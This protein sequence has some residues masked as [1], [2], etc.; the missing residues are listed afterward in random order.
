MW[1][2]WLT[3]DRAWIGSMVVVFV[4][5]GV[6]AWWGRVPDGASS[7]GV[8]PQS[9]FQAPDFELDSLE[10]GSTRL[11]DLR[12]QV[13]VVNLWAT[14]CGPCRAEMSALE[15][16]WQ[17]YRD[18]GLV[19]LAVNQREAPERVQDF[20]AQLGLTFPILLDRNGSVAASY[21]TRALPTTFF[22][23]RDGAIRASVVGGPLAEA[24][25]ASKV[26]ALLEE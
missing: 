15:R 18:R 13:V 20:V 5:G 2:R 7:T 22:V 14:W 10:G 11:S 9:G 6:W 16:V 23:G 17:E 3:N 25:I 1:Q 26:L 19:V 4:L 12:G 21:R 8:A 24:L